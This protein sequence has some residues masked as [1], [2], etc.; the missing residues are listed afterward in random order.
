MRTGLGALAAVDAAFLIAANLDGT[1]ER[2]E[3]EDC[4][5]GASVAAPEI[6]DEDGEQ[7]E[8]GN[9][10]E[11]GGT[12]VHKK[13]QHFDVGED[14]VGLRHEIFE[15]RGAHAADDEDEERHKQIFDG[16]QRNIEPARK[17]KVASEELA[18]RFP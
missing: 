1:G 18:A 17:D 11:R 5:V 13:V 9:D 12:H 10:D 4:A 3:R 7:G 2:G 6:F 15:R 8:D 16:A 14:A